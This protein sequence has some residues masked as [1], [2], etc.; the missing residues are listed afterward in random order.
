[1]KKTLLVLATVAL[2]SPLT[3]LAS[4]DVSLKYGMSGA[5]V[6]ELQELLVSESCLSVSPTGYFG[7]MTLAGVKCF[8]TKHTLPSTGYFG[9]MSRGVAN[10]LLADLTRDSDAAEVAE[11]GTSTPVAPTYVPVQPTQ[12]PVKSPVVGSQ[13]SV[14]PPVV[15]SLQEYS[16]NQLCLRQ[17]GYNEGK[18]EYSG[19]VGILKYTD[20]A[21]SVDFVVKVTADLGSNK[22]VKQPIL[23]FGTLNGSEI[24]SGTSTYEFRDNLRYVVGGGEHRIYVVGLAQNM[25]VTV[26]LVSATS[27]DGTPIEGAPIKFPKVTYQLCQ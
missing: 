22:L 27:A 11:T 25:S 21:K 26:E 14:K 9:V 10:T 15:F 19:N 24:E 5:A 20:S 3:A 6:F 17:S 16:A 4:F 8:Q 2:L 23:M 12:I 13:T 7:A 18:P 1:M